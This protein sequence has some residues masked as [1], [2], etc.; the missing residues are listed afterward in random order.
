MRSI[1]WIGADRREV[2]AFAVAYRSLCQQEGRHPSVMPLRLG[3]LRDQGLYVRPTEVRD[4]QMWDVVS[5]A[6]MSTEF[7]ISRFFVPLISSG[8]DWAVFMDCDVLLRAPIRELLALADERYA[9]QVVKHDHQPTET[10]KMD[11]QAQ[12]SY[13][14][15]NWSSVMLWNLRHPVNALLTLQ[16]LNSWTGRDLHRF[17]WLPDQLIGA[18]PAEW[19]H[20]V[21]VDPPRRDAK[22]VHFTLGTP[23]MEG[24]GD[25]EYADE[26]WA[27]A[28]RR[29]L[30]T[31]ATF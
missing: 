17:R 1:V 18:L 14:R 15:K 28:E 6:P 21:G 25:C 22:L 27:F 8:F 4:G 31:A 29:R 10:V 30:E 3:S 11:G 20:L 2:D 13:P 16:N 5:D 9:M 19:N 26:W 12:T 23:S 7:A 24:Y